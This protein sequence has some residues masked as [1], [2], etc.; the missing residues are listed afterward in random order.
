MVKPH[1]V[2]EKTEIVLN[3]IFNEKTDKYIKYMNL[4]ETTIQDFRKIHIIKSLYK[5]LARKRYQAIFKIFYKEDMG[6]K[7][8]SAMIREYSKG[9]A[10]FLLLASELEPKQLLKTLKEL[11]GW[12]QIID[13]KKKQIFRFGKG[14]RGI[15][16]TPVP[17]ISM[18]N[19]NDEQIIMVISNVIHTPDKIDESKQALPILLSEGEILAIEDKVIGL[20]EFMSI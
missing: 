12:E 20:K 9:L 4:D 15:L 19:L 8:Y 2:K 5:S 16:R 17:K 10:C 7:Y 6:T 1:A 11:K 13:Y 18:V 3:K 14:L